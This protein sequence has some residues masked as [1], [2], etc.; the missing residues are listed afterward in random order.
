MLLYF[1]TGRIFKFNRPVSPMN[2]GYSRI[3]ENLYKSTVTLPVDYLYF[4]IDKKFVNYHHGWRQTENLKVNF[5]KN[6]LLRPEFF[7]EYAKI[8]KIRKMETQLS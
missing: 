6:C 5:S 2:K 3:N 4:C 8:A 7:P 1:S